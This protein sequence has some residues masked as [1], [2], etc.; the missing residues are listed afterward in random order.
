M[1]VTANLSGVSVIQ[2]YQMEF[3]N[4]VGYTGNSALLVSAIYGLMGVLGQVI[5]I[6]LVADKRGRKTTMC[7]LEPAH[8][9]INSTDSASGIG[10]F[11]LVICNIITMAMTATVGTSK[12]KGE[13]AIAFIFIYSGCYAIFFSSTNYLIISEI[14]PFHL[15]AVGFGVSDFIGNCVGIA[16]AQ[17][18]PLAFEG[19]GWK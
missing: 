1:V 6:T 9:D 7:K 17:V 10:S 8:S 18:S 13:V 15:R 16:L 4:L 11:V 3:Y 14:F 5:N 19:I 2:N 12:T